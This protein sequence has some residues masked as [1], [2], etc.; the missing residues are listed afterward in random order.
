MPSP[1]VTK[2]M[3]AAPSCDTSKGRALFLDRN[4]FLFT[5]P[6]KIIDIA[7]TQSD[8]LARYSPRLGQQQLAEAL[9]NSFALP[10]QPHLTHGAEDGLWKVLSLLRL[11]FSQIILTDLSWGTYE[12]LSKNLGYKIVTLTTPLQTSDTDLNA[13]DLL[14]RAAGPASPTVVLMASPNNPTGHVIDPAGWQRL[15]AAHPHHFFIADGVYS[16]FAQELVA[17]STSAPNGVFVGSMS[18]FFGIAGLRVGWVV[19][20][21]SFGLG[22]A[23][24]L[25][26]GLAP[27][28]LRVAQACL[29]HKKIYEDFRVESNQT[30]Q[31]MQQI[32][33][34]K[35]LL[36]W[37]RPPAPFVLVALGPQVTPL[38]WQQAHQY[39][40]EQS[41][42]YV[43][44]INSG[45]TCYLRVSLGPETVV[46]RM[47][48][49]L[50]SLL[51]S[52]P[53]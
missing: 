30:A 15:I 7:Q 43:K 32:F 6:P 28:A 25:P 42:C 19:T 41:G 49:F 29:E 5:H 13:L 22:P 31:K 40:Q 17:A 50:E 23:L 14:L 8:D 24:D 18:K 27:Q 46:P 51:Q 12:T 52:V 53:G 45:G 48:L 36:C 16:T 37:H 20:S 33:A 9:K 39:A 26:L 1:L 34:A 38:R 3:K 44:F 35:G 47:F 2:K 11:R 10:Y 4:E 21:D